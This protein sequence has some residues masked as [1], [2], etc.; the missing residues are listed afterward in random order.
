MKPITHQ[1]TLFDYNSMRP[2]TKV[3]ISRER[4]EAAKKAFNSGDY[5]T[6]AA[7]LRDIRESLERYE[8][9]LNS[10]NNG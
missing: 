9:R 7:H 6:S 1:F 5:S 4:I 2:K 8:Q 10:K 3:P